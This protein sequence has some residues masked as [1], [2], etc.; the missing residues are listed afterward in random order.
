MWELYY[1]YNYVVIGTYLLPHNLSFV[2]ITT[3]GYSQHLHF[4]P[5]CACIFCVMRLL[6]IHINTLSL[7]L[8]TICLF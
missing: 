4:T 8:E 7:C 6:Y 1:N 2:L 5:I 3:S